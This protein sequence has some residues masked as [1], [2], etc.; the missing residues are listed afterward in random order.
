MAI[1]AI[2]LVAA[3]FVGAA[4]AEFSDTPRDVGATAAGALVYANETVNVSLMVG[5]SSKVNYLSIGTLTSNVTS[6]YSNDT[7]PRVAAVFDLTGLSAG[8][9]EVIPDVSKDAQARYVKVETLTVKTDASSYIVGDTIT[10]NASATTTAGSVTLV[11]NGVSQTIATDGTAE[12]TFTAAAGVTDITISS[13]GAPVATIEVTETSAAEIEAF[14]AEPNATEIATGS[15]VT[16]AINTPETLT[17]PVWLS[18]G[19]GTIEKL[20]FSSGTTQSLTHTYVLADS[21]PVIV[22][23]GATAADSTALKTPSQ[24]SL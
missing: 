18:W 2:F 16:L 4:S 12:A 17:T 3:L 9:V 6:R 11:Y 24:L 22:M 8:N 23:N 20:D 10:V 1:F 21:Y 5:N 13:F 15:P 19:D 7:G 14:T